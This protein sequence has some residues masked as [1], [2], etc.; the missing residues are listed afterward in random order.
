MQNRFIHGSIGVG[1]GAL[2]LFSSAV[3]IWIL[4]IIG[5]DVWVAH[6][7]GDFISLVAERV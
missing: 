4:D 7:M 5:L 6:T 3:G 1:V 2:G